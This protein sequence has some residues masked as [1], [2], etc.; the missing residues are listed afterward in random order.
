M[1]MTV[2]G[3]PQYSCDNVRR[4]ILFKQETGNYKYIEQDRVGLAKTIYSIITLKSYP[5]NLDMNT[6]EKINPKLAKVIK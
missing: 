2:K 5:E 4:L 6:V 3:V 1:F